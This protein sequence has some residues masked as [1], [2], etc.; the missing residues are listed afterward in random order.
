[1]MSKEDNELL[2]C[3]GLGTPMGALL[4][5]YWL[6]TLMVEE[7][8]EPGCAPVRTTLMGEKLVVIRDHDNNIGALEEF[9][10][11]RN[12]SLFFGRNESRNSH[13]GQ[14]GLRPDEPEIARDRKHLGL[15][16]PD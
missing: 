14:C 15:L 13:D 12:T 4:R 10:L 9:C 3:V 7:L 2:T 1:M 6:P 5:H 8:P 11:H 16:P